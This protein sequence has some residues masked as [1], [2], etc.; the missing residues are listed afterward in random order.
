MKMAFAG[1]AGRIPTFLDPRDPRPAREQFAER[2]ID[3]WEP[4]DGF[5]MLA[6]PDGSFALKY[7]GD[8][9]RREVAHGVFRDELIVLFES[10]WVAIVQRAD[11]SYEIARMT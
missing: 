6:L 11:A 4:F 8:P 9:L 10:D 2:Y 1:Y 5:E 3:G 7:P